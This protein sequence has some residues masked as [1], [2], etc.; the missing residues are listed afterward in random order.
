MTTL[1]QVRADFKKNKSELRVSGVFSPLNQGFKQVQW[2][3][4]LTMGLDALDLFKIRSR[5]LLHGSLLPC[6]RRASSFWL[7]E[8]S[9]HVQD[10]F[11]KPRSSNSWFISSLE[12]ALSHYVLHG[13][14]KLVAFGLAVDCTDSGTTDV[15]IV[16]TTY[17]YHGWPTLPNVQ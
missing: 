4:P 12:L 17:H 8:G 11:I 9:A 6:E 7:P 5:S 14:G 13:C 15:G 10:L 3:Q 1:D 16:I 2:I